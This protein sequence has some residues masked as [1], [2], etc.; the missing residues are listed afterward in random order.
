MLVSGALDIKLTKDGNVCLH[1]MQIKHPTASLIARVA[2]AQDDI[3][4][5]GT[6]SC[7]LLIAELLKQADTLMYGGV[8]FQA[9][10]PRIVASGFDL[11]KARCLAVLEGMKIPLE[12]GAIPHR[13]TLL[14]V[15]ATSLKTKL[16]FNLAS[17]LA[18]NIVDAVVAVYDPKEDAAEQLDLHRVEIMQMQHKR[19]MDS[20]LVR[21]IV[22]DHGG[23]H[24]DM[25]KRVDNAYIFTCNISM[26][27]EKTEINSSFFYKSASERDKLVQA[28]REFI[29]E[30][31]RK[32]IALKRRV[33]DDAASDSGDS[34]PNFVVIN[35]K[36][37]DPLSLDLL[38]KEGILALRRAKRRNME[39]MA[40][41]CG[42]YAVNCADNLT[43]DCLGKAGLVYEYTL[44]E[45]K[46][47]FVEQCA[48]PKSVTLLIKGPNKHTL[49]QIKDAINDG[50]KAVRNT[51]ADKCVVP[52]AGAL[53]LA[54]ALDLEQYRQT[55]S[56]REAFGVEAFQNAMMV[57]PSVLAENSA[58][59]VKEC[60][61]KMLS[62]VRRVRQANGGKVSG[63][64]AVGLDLETGEPMQPAAAGVFDN[65]V[66]KKQIIESATVIASNLLLVDEMM[67]AGLESLKG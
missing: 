2:T 50:M 63:T 62:E 5:D 56:G 51:I 30:R 39:R 16:H 52:G 18:E 15:A 65:Y 11:A 10:H 66:V 60:E 28:E 45:D 61:A 8:R 58:F 38:A 55:L 29:D 23:R 4:G 46:F 49:V 21:G 59:D 13:A 24:P 20:T 9:L 53:E 41:A 33:C 26:E 6:T 67:R 42:G 12:G 37:I 44:G 1:E 14:N 19:D 57:I 35:Q 31:V 32:I 17:S 54:C 27:Y 40:L 7:V 47:T 25:P 3:T 48:N 64:N 36:G 34:K 43:E 22:L